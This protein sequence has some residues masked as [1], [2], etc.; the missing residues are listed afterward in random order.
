M[1][2]QS[3]FKPL[4][5]N[6]SI[7]FDMLFNITHVLGEKAVQWTQ[8]RI[9]LCLRIA[10]NYDMTEACRHFAEITAPRLKGFNIAQYTTYHLQP[11]KEFHLHTQYHFGGLEGEA[12]PTAS[13]LLAGIALLVLF[14]ASINYINLALGGASRRLREVGV[15]KVM[16][17]EKAQVIRQFIIETSLMVGGSMGLGL[18]MA[19][20]ALPVFNQLTAKSIHIVP[21]GAPMTWGA[22]FIIAIFVIGLSG[23]F[24]ALRLANIQ[25]SALFQGRMK[26]IGKKR[27][28][29]GLIVFQ[30]MVS[31]FLVCS[32]LVILSQHRYMLSRHFGSDMSQVIQV[33]MGD[34]EKSGPSLQ[35]QIRAL[36]NKLLSLP[37]VV[38]VTN[39]QTSVFETM[40]AIAKGRNGENIMVCRNYTDADYLRIMR[41]NLQEG[42]LPAPDF[43]GKTAYVT[44]HFVQDAVE[45]NAI[46]KTLREVLGEGFE[47]IPIAG[48]ID[49]FFT[50]SLKYG[51]PD[52]YF[53]VD[54]EAPYGVM[55]IAMA[56]QSLHATLD[57]IR[58]A[59][60]EIV[61]NISFTYEFMDDLAAKDY[62]DESRWSRIVQI[63]SAVA[64]F[65][66]FSG[67]FGLTLMAIVRRN[68]ELS[69]RKVLGASAWHVYGLVQK[70]FLLLIVI[71]NALAFPVVYF[72]MRDWLNDF[73]HRTSLSWWIYS[74]AMMVTL[75]VAVI[76]IGIHGF[77]VNRSNPLVHLRSE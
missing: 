48:V 24:P 12:S 64:L 53:V 57:D 6:S 51:N 74:A 8:F 2:W 33:K 22:I 32:T 65:I 27:L 7:R 77:R 42:A 40:G 54:N 45:G 47:D 41:M 76:T 46:G 17:A 23:V 10:P 43:L 28:S 58:E 34:I 61:P 56:G 21:F 4:P 62:A 14:V 3:V 55:N 30:F 71:G 35:G 66:A 36:K 39:S 44:D 37:G 73:A 69:I 15:R 26:F 25:P 29:G 75:L 59:F 9:P 31:S 72:V 68:K 19:Q 49:D 63:S 5:G 20:L 38:G 16:G 1:K 13:L 70:E 60:K 50:Q 11:L 52:H 18:L 67:L